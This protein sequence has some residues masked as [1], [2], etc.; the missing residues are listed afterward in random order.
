MPAFEALQAT[1][2]FFWFICMMSVMAV[3][4]SKSG[5]GGALGSLSTPILLFV[6]PPKVALGVLLPLFLITD[7]WVVYIWRNFLNLRFVLIMCA[8]GVAGQLAGWLLFDYF[9]DRML[10]GLIGVVGI[11]T[12]LNYA[13]QI[14]SPNGETSEEVG[15]RMMRRLWPRAFGWCGLSGLASFVSLSG[16]IPAQIFLLPH[17]LARQAFVG[18]MSVYFFVINVTKLPFYSD[19]GLFT[20]DTITLSAMLV[21]IIP[22]GVVLGKWLNRKLSDRIFYH[23]SHIVLF[24][25]SAKLLY[26]AVT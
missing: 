20:V 25:M 22:F 10:T 6:L 21:P 7:V 8:F 5:F 23:F 16:G 1:P 18:T 12:A 9:S 15:A 19:L 11:T 4:V 14:V 2:L 17:G 26:G 24:A 13:R 3:S